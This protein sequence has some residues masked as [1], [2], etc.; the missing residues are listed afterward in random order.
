M[1]RET[2]AK[3]LRTLAMRN[4]SE[5]WA[6]GD[7]VQA[8]GDEEED[9]ETRVPGHGNMGFGDTGCQEASKAHQNPLQNP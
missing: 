9:R 1:I 8:L 2:T 3:A 6:I 4:S 5:G 7:H